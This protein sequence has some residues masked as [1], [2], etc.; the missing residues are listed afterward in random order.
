MAKTRR[1]RTLASLSNGVLAHCERVALIAAFRI[2]SNQSCSRRR[3]YLRFTRAMIVD[4]R[5]PKALQIRKRT[6]TVGDFSPSSSRL[7]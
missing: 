2:T 4:A 5:T 3:L 1:F 7:T 6:C